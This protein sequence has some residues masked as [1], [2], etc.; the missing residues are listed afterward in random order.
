MTNLYSPVLFKNVM[1]EWGQ[2]LKIIT[3]DALP[4]QKKDK[5]IFA[6]KLAVK[7]L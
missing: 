7:V 4:R 1:S 6:P 5:Y 2:C 3:A